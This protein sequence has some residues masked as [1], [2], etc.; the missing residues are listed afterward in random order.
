MTRLKRQMTRLKR[1]MTR[2]KPFTACLRRQMIKGLRQMTKWSER[3]I[4]NFMAECYLPK[5][6]LKASANFGDETCF[7][8][9]LLQK[10]QKIS[11]QYRA[12]A[13][14]AFFE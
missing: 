7:F 8:D 12:T 14:F 13:I 9:E 1:Q 4:K 10:P 6:C 5:F 3:M 2:L 11:E